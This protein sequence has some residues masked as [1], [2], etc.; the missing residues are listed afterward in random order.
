MSLLSEEIGFIKLNVSLT[1]QNWCDHYENNSIEAV[2][3]CQKVE[4]SSG[5]SDHVSTAD[6]DYMVDALTFWVR[7]GKED[8]RLGCPRN[9]CND[10]FIVRI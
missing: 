3:S 5:L 1:L 2:Q 6:S 8:A 9:A 4:T 7:D 10:Y